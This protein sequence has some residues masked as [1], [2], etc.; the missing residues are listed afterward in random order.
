MRPIDRAD[1]RPAE[2]EPPAR[3]AEERML[4]Q[5]LLLPRE[6]VEDAVR[7]TAGDSLR[8]LIATDHRV[9]LLERTARTYRLDDLPF[10]ALHT[11]AVEEHD[12]EAT[13]CVRGAGRALALAGLAAPDA[14]R[15]A[16]RVRNSAAHAVVTD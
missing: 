11:V 3:T 14:E 2:P 15:F 1:D 6:T 5:G 13:I 7:I 8:S 12:G 9:V 4:V 16:T 10:E